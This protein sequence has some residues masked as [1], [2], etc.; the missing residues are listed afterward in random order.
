M[1]IVSRTKPSARPSKRKDG[2][3]SV[4]L[5]TKAGKA[6]TVYGSTALEAAAKYQAEVLAS[7][8]AFDDSMLTGAWLERYADIRGVGKA[9]MT[10]DHY[11]RFCRLHLLPAFGA[12]RLRDLRGRLLEAFF[13][14]FAKS[15]RHGGSYRQHLYDFLNSA[16]DRL[17]KLEILAKNPLSVVDRPVNP[18]KNESGA[19]PMTRIELTAFFKALNGHRL[20][21]MFLLMASVGLRIGEA[22]ALKWSDLDGDVLQVRRNLQRE[23]LGK[24]DPFGPCKWGSARDLPLHAQVFTMLETWRFAQRL[25]ADSE[26]WNAHGLVFSSR[27]GTPLDAGNVRRLMFQT[28]VKACIQD[29]TT[30]AMRKTFAVRAFDVGLPAHEVQALMGHADA[31][32][33]LYYA[34][35]SKTRNGSRGLSLDNLTE[36]LVIK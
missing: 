21:P 33:T 19:Q 16:L 9:Q 17:V 28:C 24:P 22:L 15:K 30:H 34:R 1:V 8:A 5:L 3:H 2:R 4:R 31:R 11:K 23:K 36:P 13:F 7:G 10:K 26:G 12:V 29:N 20:Q 32:M 18:R 27:D 14:E 6:R 25:E 35:L